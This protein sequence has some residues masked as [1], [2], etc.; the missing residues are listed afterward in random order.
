MRITIIPPVVFAATLFGAAAFA[1]SNGQQSATQRPGPSPEQSQAQSSG[2]QP[3][4]MTQHKLQQSLQQAGFKDVK[5]LDESFLVQAQSADGT[6][7][8]MMVN[9]A[10]HQSA[11]LS[12]QGSG[13]AA[14]ASNSGGESGQTAKPPGSVTPEHH[15]T[16]QDQM[17]GNKSGTTVNPP[18]Q[19]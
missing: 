3:R 15:A 5:I 12:N 16:G 6:P 7:V 9:P 2:T 10:S 4:L 18:Q 14:A 1:Q 8:V 19:R 11:A 13:G 17:P